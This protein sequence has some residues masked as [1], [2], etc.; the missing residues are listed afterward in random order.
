MLGKL[1]EHLY[2]KVFV[3][4][5]LNRSNTVV[6]IE[7]CNTK[8]VV[9]SLEES[10][11]TTKLNNKVYDFISEY[12]NESP[13]HYISF[14]DPSP[15]QGAIHTCDTRKMELFF[16][17]ESSKYRCYNDKWA[18]YTSKPDLAQLQ[19]EYK[20]LGIDF[21]FSPFALLANFFKDK[22]ETHLAMFILIEENYISLGVFDNSELLFARHLDMQN[23]HELDELMIDDENIEEDLDL[24]EDGS[25]DLEDVDVMDDLDAFGDIEDLDT[26][27]EIEE[28]AEDEELQEQVSQSEEESD[29]GGEFN[30]DYQRFSLIQSAINK[31]YKDDIYNSKFVEAAYIADGVGISGDLKRYLEEE[32]FLNVYVRSIDLCAEV[33]EL[34]K[35]EVQ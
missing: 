20:E 32:M 7:L 9:Q 21:I 18:L 33:C 19:K 22:I 5:V 24:D 8:G 12:I 11:H 15:H 34:A 23:S 1:F 29:E 14:L 17:K 4:I 13:Y 31:F 16:D 35:V 10:F 2:L 27:E 26:I 3:N 28:F 30:E 6:Y 25:I